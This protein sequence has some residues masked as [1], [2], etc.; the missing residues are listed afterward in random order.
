MA[1]LIDPTVSPL[2]S[3]S[4]AVVVEPEVN[5]GRRAFPK[6][7]ELFAGS[8][9]GAAQ[10]LDTGWYDTSVHI[11]SGA[12]ALVAAGAGLDDLIGEIV[13]VVNP[14]N[15]LKALV[16]VMQAASIPTSFA[17]ARR[18]WMAIARPSITSLDCEV[19]VIG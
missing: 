16:Y 8:P 5:I 15:G 19:T 2:G 4:A 13:Q 3:V 12:F 14:G 11:E 17:I 6:S 18:A 1:D 7:Q 9:I 10:V